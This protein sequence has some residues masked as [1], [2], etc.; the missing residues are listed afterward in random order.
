MQALLQVVVPGNRISPLVV[1]SLFFFLSSVSTWAAQTSVDDVHVLPRANNAGE[2]IASASIPP[3]L[4]SPGYAI[5][6]QVDLVL[7]PVTVTDPRQRLVIGLGRD[8]FQ[9]YDGKKAQEIRHFSNEDMPVSIG[10]I[11]DTSGSMKDKI[12]RVRE[13][14]AQFCESANPEDEFFMITFSSAP[15]L[16]EDFTSSPDDI[17]K[18]MLSVQPKGRT[19]LLDAIYMGLTKMRQAKYP[20]RALLIISDGGDNNSRYGEREVRSVLKEAD[21]AVYAIGTFDRYVPTHEE[22]LGPELLS[23]LAEPTGGRAFT[24]SNINDLPEVAGRIATELRI[25]YVLG[26]RPSD[27]TQDG[28]WH[29]IHVKLRMPRRLAML[30]AHTKAGYY[31]QAK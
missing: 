8:N 9:V 13:A 31:A 6:K 21:V 4:G 26:Y 16:A 10:I 2:T 18:Q 12:E 20:K 24:I 1:V 25:Q 17:Q 22:A 27:T 7:V 28:K 29:K 14:V 5:R 3:A 23:S 30:Q 11:V 15:R 19:A